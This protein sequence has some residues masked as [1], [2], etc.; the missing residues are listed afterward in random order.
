[1]DSEFTKELTLEEKLES[2]KEVC[3]SSLSNSIPIEEG[4][5][6]ID[7]NGVYMYNKDLGLRTSSYETMEK[8]NNE[9]IKIIEGNR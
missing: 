4:N 7:K 5:I 2:L 1:M 3:K 9:E 8:I 6:G